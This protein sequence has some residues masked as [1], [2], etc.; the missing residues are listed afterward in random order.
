MLQNLRPFNSWCFTV[1]GN[2]IFD[3]FLLE[4]TTKAWGFLMLA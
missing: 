3:N 4:F 2:L 1:S